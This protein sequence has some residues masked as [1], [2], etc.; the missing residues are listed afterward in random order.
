MKPAFLLICLLNGNVSSQ[1]DFKNVNTCKYFA[2]KLN[3]QEIT[4]KNY[5]CFCR[6]TKVKKDRRLW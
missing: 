4:D 2:K 6:L 5:E 3:N 1:L